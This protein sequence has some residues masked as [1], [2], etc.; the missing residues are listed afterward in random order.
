MSELSSHHITANSLNL[1]Y[2]E[3]GEGDPILLLHGFPTSSHLYR[4]ILPE[5]GK[6]H[7]PSALDLPGYGLSDKPLDVAYDYDFYADTLDAFL[8]ALNNSP[9]GRSARRSKLDKCSVYGL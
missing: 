5:L 6:T 7:R 4:N 8:D 3:A 9:R 1:H 2:L